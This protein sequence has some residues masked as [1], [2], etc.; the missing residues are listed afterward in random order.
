MNFEI[1]IKKKSESVSLISYENAIEIAESC[2]LYQMQEIAQAIR[3]LN[4]LGSL[5]HFETPGLKD[6]IVINP[7][8]RN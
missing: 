2:G 3:F 8:V 5:Q 1:E 6:K 7:Q 4:D